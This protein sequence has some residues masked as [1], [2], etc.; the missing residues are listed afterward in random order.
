MDGTGVFNQSG[1]TLTTNFLVLDN[2]GDSPAGIGQPDGIDRYN[3]SGGTLE[4]KSVWGLIARNTTASVSLSGGTIKNTGSN[5]DVAIN[6]PLAVTNTVTLDTNGAGNKFSLMN[7]ALGAGTLALSGGGIIELEPDSNAQR[8]GT[9]TGTG[10]QII[11]AALSGSVALSKVGTGTTTLSGNGAAY[12]GSVTVNA[13][14]LNIPS[15]LAAGGIT[16]A[17]G[18]SLSGEA[19]VINLSLGTVGG[20]NLFFDPNTAGSLTTTNL[21]VEGLTLLDVTSPPSA[22]TVTALTYLTKTGAGTF[23]IAN[24]SSYRG[25]PV[26]T[27]TGT[28]ITVTFAAG[29]ALTWTGATDGNWNINSS[30]NWNNTDPAS[31]VFFTGDSV[32]FPEGAANPSITLAGAITPTSILVSADTTNYTLTSSGANQITGSTGLTKTGG[33]TLTLAGANAYNGVTAIN[34]GTLSITAANNIGSGAVGNS[35]SFSG[36]GK[37]SYAGTTALDL[38][39]NRSF[40]I[41]TGG[42]NLIHNSATATTLSV[43]GSISGSAALGFQSASSGG[44]TFVLSGN[45]SGYT[46]AIT[47]DSF[48]TGLTTLRLNNQASVPASGSITV[49]FPANGAA[50]NSSTLD[51]QGVTT[52]SG[53]TLNFTNGFNGANNVRSTLNSSGDSIVNGPVK[54]NGTGSIVQVFSN[55]GTITFNGN[56]SESTPGSYGTGNTFF[57]RGVAAVVVNGTINLPGAQVAH[58]D[59]GSV[60]FAST[61][62]TWAT[63]THALGTMN[64]AVNDALSTTAPLTL[65]QNDASAATFNLGGFNQTIGGLA[66]NPTTV[67]AN[68]TTKVI[69][70]AT[71]ST[72]TVNQ[73]ADNTYAGNITGAVSLVKGGASKLTLSGT[74]TY[75]GNITV[76]AGTLEAGGTQ[77]SNALGSPTTAGRTIAVNNGSTLL[78]STNN[79][80]GGGVG[81]PN[82]PS[83]TV[84][85]STLSSTRYNAVGNLTLNAA[86]LTQASTDGAGY[87]GYQFF[88][89]VTVGGASASTISTTNGKGNHLSVSSTSFVVADV[90]SSAASDLIVSAPLK[91]ASTDFAG[92]PSGLVKSGAG[93]MALSGVNTYTGATL[94]SSG[95]LQIGDGGTTG[96]IAPASAIT[97][98]ATL[99]FNRTNTLT[100]GTDFASVISG[101]GGVTQ[102]GTGITV[103]TGANTYTG[104]T[105]VNAGT[106]QIGNGGT[107]GSLT[108][109]SSIT[110]NASLVFNRSNS[111]TQGTDFNS[112]ISGSGSVAQAGSGTTVLNGTNTYSGGTTVTTGTLSLGGSSALGTGTATV[113][114]GTL[115]LGGQSV[116]NAVTI[117]SAGTLSGSG[118]TGVTSLAGTVN[119]GGSSSGLITMATA[120]VAPSSVLNLQLGPVGSSTRGTDYDAITVS[121]TLALDGTINVTLNGLTPSIG[122]TF[123]LINSTG[124]INV[125]NFTVATDLVLPSLALGLAWD[126]SSFATNGTIS[127][128]SSDPFLGWASGYG[129]SGGD[130]A[131]SADPDA[132]GANNLLEF[133]TNANPT[134][135]GSGARAYVKMHSLGGDNVL[136]YTIATRKTASFAANGS[137]QEATKDKVKYTVQASNDLSTWTSVVVTEVTGGD[138][139]SVQSA[140]SPALPALDADWE[141]HTFRTDGGTGSDASDYIRLK[142]EE[143]P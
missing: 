14:R 98:N 81:N 70:S 61:G 53:L 87:E 32:E 101:S 5:I 62:N 131:K 16:V 142:V 123:D 3:L 41:G 118:S 121:D 88:G 76:N 115:N 45:N 75:T 44:G 141:W 100:Q 1:G 59:G 13:G 136:T 139:S 112:V 105:T 143:V 60:T 46:G 58:T 99:A 109:S 48:S 28:A 108:P 57:L 140:I 127:V 102:A 116:S 55:S 92:A 104:A 94:I 52:P 86:T 56:V 114:G 29:K 4:L 43:T 124:P 51:L 107:A 132:D 40:A 84:D 8:L 126:T 89:T 138:A 130:A 82:L 25:A 93:T 39:S 17:D 12:T 18:A 78:F 128:I 33:S 42:G 73:G 79:V 67:G 133:A 83:V 66:S 96:S 37:L 27:D 122:Q 80:F 47:V 21:A 49:N 35:L 30:S 125:T 137:V 65:G 23:D 9:S 54:L 134:S 91:N 111:L 85:G 15:T 11:S 95:T 113:S 34:G 72:L 106:L 103:I 2:R 135:G 110:V 10:S 117:G 20:S 7:D 24:A 31:D 38:G 120:A 97:D 26:V 63:T 74:N 77:S 69:T 68:T 6:A 22:G 64:I 71:A 36:G 129:L 19:S 90:T 50:G 119:P